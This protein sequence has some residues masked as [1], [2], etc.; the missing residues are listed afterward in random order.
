M[1]Y[2]LKTDYLEM[3]YSAEEASEFDTI[4]T[5]EAIEHA[6]LEL[7]FRVDRIGHVK[8]LVDRLARGE[9]WDIVFNFYEGTH[10]LAC[11]AQ[12]PCLLDAYDIPY[13]FSDASI[14]ALALDKG[15]TK[16]VLRERGVPT[17]PFT[18][19]RSMTELKQLPGKFPLFVKPLAEG[20]SKGIH[21]DSLVKNLKE[22]RKTSQK[23]FK[24]G[25]G[26]LLVETFLPGEEFTVGIGGT[27]NA[28][29]VLGVMSIKRKD[30]GKLIY[31]YEAKQNYLELLD[32]KL[33]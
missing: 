18:V 3:G 13:V 22:L 29:R 10:G 11:E 7:G 1:T 14:L 17:A 2:D 24:K 16:Q 23:L 8:A 19:A 26:P 4:D 20:S 21:A 31:S 6:L 5:V 9:R 28:A 30:G 27:G 15:L 25:L 12:V 32:Y 33:A